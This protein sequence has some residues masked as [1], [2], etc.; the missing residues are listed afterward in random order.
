MD[1]RVLE[2]Q[3]RVFG[4]CFDGDRAR[5]QSR[6]SCQ[7]WYQDFMELRVPTS[8]FPRSDNSELVLLSAHFCSVADLFVTGLHFWSRRLEVFSFTV[9]TQR[10]CTENSAERFVLVI[11]R[12]KLRS[13]F[14][15]PDA[16]WRLLAELMSHV[17]NVPR[18]F[19]LMD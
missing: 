15:R 11:S 5:E 7:V 17:E 9:Q 8:T 14:L 10:W 13:H 12:I 16:R 1:H 6:T 2:T 3:F 4:S 18:Q 19:Q